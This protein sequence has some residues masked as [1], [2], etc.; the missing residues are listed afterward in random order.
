MTNEP[1]AYS[2]LLLL[3]G[4]CME[5]PLTRNHFR[6]NIERNLSEIYV[7][8]KWMD[9]VDTRT[10]RDMAATRITKVHHETTDDD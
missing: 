4:E 8:G 6:Y 10:A 3:F 5:K 7:D 1:E 9:A 2:P